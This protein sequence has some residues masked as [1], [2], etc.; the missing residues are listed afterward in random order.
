MAL[1]GQQIRHIKRVIALCQTI[2]NFV[3]EEDEI[4]YTYHRAGGLQ[5]SIA[6]NSEAYQQLPEIEGLT[7]QDLADAEYALAVIRDAAKNNNF[8]QVRLF[9][10]AKL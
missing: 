6:L 7:T 10:E 8:N 1:T 2:R 9:A 4:D 3:S 5:A